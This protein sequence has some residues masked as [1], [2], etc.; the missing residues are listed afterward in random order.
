MVKKCYTI[1]TNRF[2]SITVQIKNQ[3][4]SVWLPSKGIIP[5]II[6]KAVKRFFQWIKKISSYGLKKIVNIIGNSW[7]SFRVRREL[8][9]R[10]P[11]FFENIYQ[12]IR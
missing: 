2:N 4:I 10:C 1:S 8:L 3:R 5:E 9:S 11:S 12:K 7:L 6:D